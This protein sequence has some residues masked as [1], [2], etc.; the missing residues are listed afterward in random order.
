MAVCMVLDLVGALDGLDHFTDQLLCHVH[1]V[2]VV[3]IGH[4][5]LACR[6]LRVV[7][8]VDALVPE[9]PANLIH[10]LDAAHH[11]LLKVQLRGNA[12]VKLH[13][14]VVVVGHEGACSCTTGDHVHH[15]R[16]HLQEFPLI[17]VLAHK[18]DD[19]SADDKV[20]A[21][22]LVADEIQVALAVAR[23]LVLEAK[24]R[25][26]R[27]V[28]AGGQ[29]LK[30]PR[31]Q[32]QLALLGLAREAG[33]THDVT[34]L[35]LIVSVLKG[36]QLKLRVP[37]ISH[38]LH[39]SALASQV[40]EQQLGP[41]GALVC[42]AA[43]QGHHHISQLLASLQALI[44]GNEV[45]HIHG[46]LELV[47][48]G[49]AA[50]GLLSLDDLDAVLAVLCWVQ[51]LIILFQLALTLWGLGFEAHLLHLGC[52]LLSPLSSHAVLLLALLEFT[53]AHGLSLL[54][55]QVLRPLSRQ[56]WVG[57]WG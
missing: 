37:G 33:H 31:E 28:Q 41:A 26:G 14:E 4:V 45:L 1:E 53:L 11:Q 30:G 10:A 2:V 54:I 3:R 29:Y 34:P 49:V 6:E 35:G 12:H 38:D 27:H 23:L 24:V 19:L 18:L 40:V 17:Q 9:L 16:L 25:L 48:V 15:G 21:H 8:Q 46:H 44:L 52:R 7:R 47:G 39:L 55:L 5:E 57:F 50:L 20:V 13:V 36:C 42:D 56:V 32:G 43:C 51:L 22:I